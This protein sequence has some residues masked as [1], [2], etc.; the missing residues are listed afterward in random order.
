MV[1]T[2]SQNKAVANKAAN[3]K[4]KQEQGQRRGPQAT[5][6][7]SSTTGVS[8]GAGHT[9]SGRAN[10]GGDGRPTSAVSQRNSQKHPPGLTSEATSSNINDSKK[11]PHPD[12]EHPESSSVRTETAIANGT[13]SSNSSSS[14]SSSSSNGVSTFQGQNVRVSP[15]P[16]AYALGKNTPDGECGTQEELDEDEGSGTMEQG[17]SDDRSSTSS[18]Y[19]SSDFED[20]SDQDFSEYSDEDSNQSGDWYYED[21]YNDED[22]VCSCVDEG[23]D[24]EE[25][26]AK[27]T[28]VAEYDPTSLFAAVMSTPQS[29]QSC[30]VVLFHSES[31]ELVGELSGNMGL[32]AT[33]SLC[34]SP[35]CTK[36]ACAALG[37]RV[38]D[39]NS[40]KRLLKVNSRDETVAVQFNRAGDRLLSRTVDGMI[41]IW[42]LNSRRKLWYCDCP[43]THSTRAFAKFSFDESRIYAVEAQPGQGSTWGVPDHAFS[44]WHI[45]SHAK[46]FTTGNLKTYITDI[47]SSPVQDAVAVGLRNS[48][49]EIWSWIEETSLFTRLGWKC[50]D[51]ARFLGFNGD[52]SK[53]VTCPE[54]ADDVTIW[55]VKSGLILQRCRGEVI[56]LKMCVNARVDR[57]AFIDAEIQVITV[58]DPETSELIQTFEGE[59]RQMCFAPG[60][61]I[62]L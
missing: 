27:K 14:S 3:D 60:C 16:A 48:T 19:S 20:D 1:T 62:L 44:C 33:H 25:P 42:D 46:V 40:R 39:V 53:L 38:W 32:D 29:D 13:T 50:G 56:V 10:D 28:R 55:E 6:A 49:L 11:R 8:A 58:I 59:F 21:E 22:S 54:Y 36:L 47:A 35:D 57:I 4:Q 30:K 7:G 23:S 26:S 18:Y 61:Q 12:S 34:F 9:S 51:V 15:P 24:N 31:F 17:S 37:V 41:R 45:E 2:R 5:T 52:G 43:V